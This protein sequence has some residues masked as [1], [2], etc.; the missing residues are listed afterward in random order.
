MSRNMFGE[1]SGCLLNRLGY[2]AQLL[3]RL[4]FIAV[5]VLAAA[6]IIQ[7][8]SSLFSKLRSKDGPRCLFALGCVLAVYLLYLTAC[9]AVQASGI[10]LFVLPVFGQL[11]TGGLGLLINVCGALAL[12]VWV[13]WGFFYCRN[14]A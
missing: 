3:I 7:D 12:M 9:A 1:G 5:L 4:S 6:V 2:I 8:V 10:A 14:N 13:L 11:T